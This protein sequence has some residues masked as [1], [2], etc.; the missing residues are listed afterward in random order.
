MK[1]LPL[2]PELETVVAVESMTVIGCTITWMLLP[3][4]EAET[5]TMP[6]NPTIVYCVFEPLP[7]TEEKSGTSRGCPT[8]LAK[9]ETSVL[10]KPGPPDIIAGLV[11]VAC[12]PFDPK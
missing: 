8:A 12:N 2:A 6:A 11:G 7:E 4:P 1:L 3:L 5:M 9:F 10:F